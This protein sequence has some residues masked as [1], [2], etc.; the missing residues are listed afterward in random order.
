[1]TRVRVYNFS[2]DHPWTTIILDSFGIRL[3]D[4]RCCMELFIDQGYTT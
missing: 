3:N 1:M 4:D 2:K